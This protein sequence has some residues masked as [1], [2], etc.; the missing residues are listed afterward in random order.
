MNKF[1]QNNI[2]PSLTWEGEFRVN[3]K[4]TET[5]AE[6]RIRL[7]REEAARLQRSRGL[8][9]SGQPASGLADTIHTNYDGQFDGGSFDGSGGT[10]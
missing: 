5:E 3:E 1:F 8:S 2:D 4:K 10:D 6:R 9:K 7:R